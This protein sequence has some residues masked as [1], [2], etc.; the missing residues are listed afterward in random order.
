MMSRVAPFAAG[1]SILSLFAWMA[2]SSS[3]QEG[4]A[5]PEEGSRGANGET[6]SE[7]S[8]PELDDP[9]VEP[10][11]WRLGRVDDRF[12]LAHDELK[13]AVVQAASLWEEAAGRRLFTFDSIGGFPVHLVYDAGQSRLEQR[14]LAEATF[15]EAGRRLDERRDELGEDDET[16]RREL[17]A[18]RARGEALERTFAPTRVEAGRYRE[19]PRGVAGGVVRIEREIHIHRFGD[20]N[21]LAWVLAHEL[22]HALGLDHLDQPGALMAEEHGSEGGSTG[23]PRVGEGELSMLR[24]ICAEP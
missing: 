2:L 21:D 4:G 6:L 12:G 3:G 8:V 11:G 20:G 1:F 13:A 16:Y 14:E 24:E 10:L 9:C 5:P 17:E 22:G 15:R 19:I 7:A 23:P 18:H